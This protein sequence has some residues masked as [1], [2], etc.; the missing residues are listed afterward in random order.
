MNNYSYILKSLEVAPAENASSTPSIYFLG[1]GGIGMSAL[2]RYFN[3]IGVKVS[4][5]DKTVTPLT[6]QLVAEGIT[7]HFEDNIELIDKAAQLVV[8]AGG[9]KR[10]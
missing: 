2:V 6:N 3:S 8:Y 10:S 5:Y 9:T 4:G 1:I 7:I